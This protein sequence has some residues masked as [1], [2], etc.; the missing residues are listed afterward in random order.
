MTTAERFN[1][2]MFK[3]QLL[4]SAFN[5][6]SESI[7]VKIAAK[8]TPG[9]LK[10]ILRMVRRDRLYQTTNFHDY[11]ACLLKRKATWNDLAE[12]ISDADEARQFLDGVKQLRY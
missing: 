6:T 10:R 2:V 1:E 4:T 11:L 9:R 3:T 7:E 12:F 5:I 8:D